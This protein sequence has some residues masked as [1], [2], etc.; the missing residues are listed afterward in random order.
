MRLNQ[1]MDEHRDTRLKVGPIWVDPRIIVYATLIQI[2]AFALYNE[3]DAPIGVQSFLQLIGVCV[4]PMFV[5]AVAHGF[6][7]ALDVQIRNQRRMTWRDRLAIFESNI[8]FIYVALLPSAV[9]VILWVLGWNEIAAVRLILG[10]GIVS[11]FFWGAYAAHAAGLPR[12]R[13]FSF[14]LG[15]AT[16]GMIVV[17][18][19][20]FIAH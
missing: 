5:L 20:V 10:M 4:V 13:W 17:T 1:T 18:L 12:W 3:P 19:E 2:T 15:Y 7:E 14:A 11:L 6:S 8:Q 9:L 16:L